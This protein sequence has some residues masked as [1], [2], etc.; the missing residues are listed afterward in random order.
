M[1][2]RVCAEWRKVSLFVYGILVP[3]GS[4]HVFSIP[5]TISG[6]HSFTIA[7]FDTKCPE[8][9]TICDMKS[10]VKCNME[11]SYKHN[12]MH[13]NFA[14]TDSSQNSSQPIRLFAYPTDSVNLFQ[15]K[16]KI[17]LG[18]KLHHYNAKLCVLRLP[19]HDAAFQHRTV[20]GTALH[21]M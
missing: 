8:L 14:S 2:T 13:K 5:D 1:I 18:K 11:L 15:N 3:V 20:R 19:Q 16:N 12:Q 6:L 4:F 21:K 9:D 10:F 17:N 7:G